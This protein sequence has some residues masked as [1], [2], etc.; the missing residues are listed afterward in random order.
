MR[1]IYSWNFPVSS[2]LSRLPSNQSGPTYLQQHQGNEPLI[3]LNPLWQPHSSQDP[4]PFP[5]IWSQIDQLY[6]HHIHC[7]PL[8][9]GKVHI[10]GLK[11]V[12]AQPIFNT[13]RPRQNGCHFADDTFN[14]IFFNENVRISFKISLKFVP[15]GLI[16]NIPALVQI[17]P[18]RLIGDKPLS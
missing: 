16:I 13:L 2:S 1:Q 9:I 6:S 5:L 4:L 7:N 18:W 15:K 8:N 11:L 17:I 14:H 3:L 10:Q 12:I